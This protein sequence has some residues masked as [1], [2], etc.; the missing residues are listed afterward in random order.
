MKDVFQR[1][2]SNEKYNN[3]QR[4][5]AISRV[6]HP[7]Y[8]SIKFT[9]ITTMLF[10][11]LH[12]GIRLLSFYNLFSL[13]FL[14]SCTF[15]FSLTYTGGSLGSRSAF[16]RVEVIIMHTLC[17]AFLAHAIQCRRPFDAM[18]AF[19]SFRARGAMDRERSRASGRGT[20]YACASYVWSSYF[21]LSSEFLFIRI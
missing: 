6:L 14:R 4:C 7:C 2:K 3:K 8:L 9:I 20:G 17:E 21:G 13:V 11:I 16:S 12:F 19:V 5:R 1:G 15:A 10:L 18:H